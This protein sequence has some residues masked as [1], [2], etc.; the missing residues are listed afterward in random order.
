MKAPTFLLLLCLY[1]LVMIN[2]S[3]TSR[4]PRTVEPF[5]GLGL[6]LSQGYQIVDHAESRSGDVKVE[7]TVARAADGR[8]LRLE[9][10]AGVTPAG[11]EGLL[12]DRLFQID[13]IYE[14]HPDLY[15]AA[16]TKKTICP[17]RYLPVHKT[18]TPSDNTTEPIQTAMLYA[19][20]RL[21]Y[22]G[23][24][25]E[26]ATQRVVVAFVYCRKNADFFVLEHFIPEKLFTQADLVLTSSIQCL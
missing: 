5:A 1:G 4:R 19:N 6:S 21:T 8:T 26:L 25:P 17:D 18:L 11:A 12:K 22:G 24:T 13:S 15:F 7:N 3:C 9:R 2:T 20:D 10:F 14:P 23:C 16:I